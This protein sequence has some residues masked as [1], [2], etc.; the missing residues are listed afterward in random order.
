MGALALVLQAMAPTTASAQLRYKDA[1][2]VTH[3][4]DSVDKL[5]PQFRPDAQTAPRPGPAPAKDADRRV[6]RE[7]PTVVPVPRF[8]LEEPRSPFTFG[9]FQ[10]IVDSCTSKTRRAFPP[11]GRVA[12][13]SKFTAYVSGPGYVSVVGSTQ[14]LAAF[15]QCLKDEGVAV[16]GK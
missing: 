1:D 6:E 16:V 10:L 4:V 13:D 14:E 2:G 8:D 5:P 12:A 7:P 11:K 3:W 15:Q 9:A